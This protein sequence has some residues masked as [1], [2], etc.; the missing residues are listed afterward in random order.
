MNERMNESLSALA[1]GEADELE[2]RRLLNQMQ[3]EDELRERWHRYQMIGALMR[4]EPAYSVDLSKGIMQVLDG[5]PMDEVPARQVSGLDV[6]HAA[7]PAQVEENAH[8]RPR[9]GWLT[10]GAV[11]A[12]V[13]LVVLLGARFMESG[14]SVMTEEPRVA[15]NSPVLAPLTAE[16]V[17]AP[18]MT[19]MT[20]ADVLASNDVDT[21]EPVLDEARL[22]EAQ[23]RLHDYV[24][25]HS[26]QAAMGTG[27]G[28]LPYAR[29]TSYEQG[30]EQQK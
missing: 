26:Q 28:L 9:S 2:I 16:A 7:A 13:A 23:Q 29:V 14:S 24:M 17:T 10:S 11:A 21:S 5:E 30:G 19:S 4:D 3:E 18:V 27:R 20:A 12:S 22:R 1:D 6:S 8:H 15:S 25:Q